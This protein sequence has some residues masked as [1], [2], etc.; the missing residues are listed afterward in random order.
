MRKIGRQDIHQTTRR[1]LL[2]LGGMATAAF[3]ANESVAEAGS[4]TL[5]PTPV[6]SR[7][8]TAAAE[9]FV[10]VDA[11]GGAVTV[12]LPAAPGDRSQ[13]GIGVIAIAVPYV[14]SGACGEGDVLIRVGGTT[15]MSLAIANQEVVLQ[16]ETSSKIWYQV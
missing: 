7:D 11:S 3:V 16:Y 6:K 10:P 14:V 1:R 8:Y 5:A 9:D 12:T 4:G 2:G 13:V 15:S